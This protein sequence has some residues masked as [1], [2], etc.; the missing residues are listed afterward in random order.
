[1]TYISENIKPP[2]KKANEFL[3]EK[4]EFTEHWS[5]GWRY[6]DG[7]DREGLPDFQH[8]LTAQERWL[9]KDD[10]VIYFGDSGYCSITI[11]MEALDDVI[12]GCGYGKTRAEQAFNACLR[13][14]GW[15]EQ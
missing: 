8:D 7:R 14:Y 5:G 4:N 12:I 13:V 1:M 6:P 11:D 9:W 2:M 3:A 10:W 15:E